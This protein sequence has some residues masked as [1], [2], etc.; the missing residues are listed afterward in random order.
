MDDENDNVPP[1][2]LSALRGDIATARAL[3]AAGEDSETPFPCGSLEG[4]TPLMAAIFAYRADVARPLLE[5]GA[6]VSAAVAEAHAHDS[7]HHFNH[8]KTQP[9]LQLLLEHGLCP[10]ERNR[11]DGGTLL[12]SYA[13]DDQ[14][15]ACARLLLEHGADV[16]ARDDWQWT[17][18]MY[19]ARHGAGDNLRLFL[20]YGADINATDATGQCALLQNIFPPRFAD[21]YA[22]LTDE[23][24]ELSFYQSLNRAPRDAEELSS[25]VRLLLS[26]GAAPQVRDSRGWSA[27]LLCLSSGN[28]EAARLLLA[29]GATLSGEN[30]MLLHRARCCMALHGYAEALQLLD[31]HGGVPNGAEPLPPIPTYRRNFFVRREQCRGTAYITFQRG[32]NDWHFSWNEEKDAPCISDDDIFTSELFYLL[33]EVIPDY[34]P[35]DNYDIS[36]EQWESI[37]ARARRLGGKPAHAIA[38][39]REWVEARFASGEGFHIYGV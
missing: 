6:T 11:E 20:Q 34:S 21:D 25:R 19:A 22:M 18:L 28:A 23:Q 37:S 30:P 27:L 26:C 1:L 12:M 33:Q 39:V 31:E 10:N 5:H 38:E 35:Y 3:L 36:R 14:C 7:H 16:N 15:H 17:P 4:L 9:M 29:H 13:M 24:A 2:Y 8:G 32:P